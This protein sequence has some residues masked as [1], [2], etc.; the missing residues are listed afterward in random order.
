M[1]IA[2]HDSLSGNPDKNEYTEKGKGEMDTTATVTA[3]QRDRYELEIGTEILY[4]R[5]KPAAFYHSK[6]IQVFP[7]VGDRVS[8]IRNTNGDSVILRV[9]ERKSVFMRL[10]STQGMPDQAVAANFDF[11]F[12]TMSL[13]K[14]FHLSKLERY[15][16]ASWQSGGI[17]VILLTK[18]DL[19]E[20]REGILSQISDLAPGVETYCISSYTGEGFE[21]LEKYLVTGNMIVLLGSSGVGKSSFVNAVLGSERMQTGEIREADSQG[22]HT[23]TFKQ[24]FDIPKKIILPDGHVINGG[25]RIID[26]PGMRN[27]LMGEGAGGIETTFKDIED[28]AMQCKFSDCRHNSEPGCAVKKALEDGTL[29]QRHWKM[30]LNLQREE[31]YSRERKKILMRKAGKKKSGK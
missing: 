1:K 13:N 29:D 9:L 14:D 28:L 31:A 25:G 24:M 27:L 6:E 16:T 26:T 10:N 7:T 12:I 4:G 5:L 11:V 22:R 17:P 19:M 15:L 30:Y 18:A 2:F 3:V 21:K 8:I 23:T 20:N